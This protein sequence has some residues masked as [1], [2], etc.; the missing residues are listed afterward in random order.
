MGRSYTLTPCGREEL[1]GTVYDPHATLIDPIATRTQRTYSGQ[2]QR[3]YFDQ[4]QEDTCKRRPPIEDDPRY[5]DVECQ[6]EEFSRSDA[7]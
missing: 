3:I 2:S 7:G 4:S 1:A 5:A 6:D